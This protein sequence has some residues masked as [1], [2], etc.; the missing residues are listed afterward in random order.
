MIIVIADDITGAAELGGIALRYNLDVMVSDDIDANHYPDV[1]IAYTNARSM[2]EKEA[3]E[4]MK[5]LTAK[6]KQLTPT[7]IY[8]KT[9]SVLRGHIVAEMKGQMKA[10]G[11]NKALLVPINPSSGR[12]IRN[13]Y[14]YIKGMPIHET[15]FSRDPEFP[16]KSSRVEDI[17]ESKEFPLRLIK[18]NEQLLPNEISVGEAETEEDLMAWAKYHDGSTLLAGGGSF[19]NALLSTT[20]ETKGEN[21]KME[22]QLSSPLCFVS[23]TTYLRNVER[24]KKY[25]SIVSY[26]PSEIF[27]RSEIEDFD[28]QS[29]LNEALE[30]LRRHNKVIIAI[31]S[32]QKGMSDP[33][34]LGDKLAEIVKLILNW[35]D[36][37]E[38][39]IEGGATAYSI[40]KKLGWREF[41]PTEEWGQGVV[42]MQIVGERNIYLTIKPGSYDWPAQWDFN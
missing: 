29:W 30:T 22:P 32:R 28:F 6:A 20:Y 39:I 2:R 26:M 27:L 11:F 35:V 21:E 34:L 19:F 37:S 7:L 18:K 24:I 12:V 36:I 3:V 33:N 31:G 38:L 14:Y 13:G 5:K 15:G 8:K 23:G 4:I 1:W 41:T 25:A 16:V 40:V 10:I 9:D 17:L 42:R